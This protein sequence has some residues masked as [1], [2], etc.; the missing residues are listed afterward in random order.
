MRVAKDTMS[1]RGDHEW[2][3]E[4]GTV[5]KDRDG[6][7]ERAVSEDRSGSLVSFAF[8]HVRLDRGRLI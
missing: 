8:S 1:V 3:H 7:L 2:P 4:I 5:S 6:G